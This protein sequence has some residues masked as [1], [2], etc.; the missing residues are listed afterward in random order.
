MQN[1]SGQTIISS[2]FIIEYQEAKRGGEAHAVM[3][4][5]EQWPREDEEVE[6]P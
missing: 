6:H 3:A 2:V 1:S 5:S 4:Y